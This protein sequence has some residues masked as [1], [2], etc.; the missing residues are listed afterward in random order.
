MTAFHQWNPGLAAGEFLSR[1]GP[2]KS[3]DERQKLTTDA[4]SV[5]SQDKIVDQLVVKQ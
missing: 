3:E 1:E 5:V 4:A 2:I